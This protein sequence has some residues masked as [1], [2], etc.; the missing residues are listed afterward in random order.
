MYTKH[1]RELFEDIGKHPWHKNFEVTCSQYHAGQTVEVVYLPAQPATAMLSR[2]EAGIPP[3]QDAIGAVI[4]GCLAIF[5]AV[6]AL[7]F[8]FRRP[9]GLNLQ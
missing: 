7:R 6:F 3:R 9:P 8:F 2:R 5:G 4:G 1:Y